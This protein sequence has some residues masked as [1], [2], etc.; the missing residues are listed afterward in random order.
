[1]RPDSV[2]RLVFGAA[3]AAVGRATQTHHHLDSVGGALQK[4]LA[5]MEKAS[6]KV[7]DG[8]LPSVF[9]SFL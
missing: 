7:R 4:V 8:A 3:S 6:R 9:F 1:M 2:V 5:G